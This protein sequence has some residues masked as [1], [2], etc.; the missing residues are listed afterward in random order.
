MFILMS[1]DLFIAKER[2]REALVKE[3]MQHIDWSDL[4]QYP[5]FETCD[6]SAARPEQKAC[7]ETTFARH[8]QATLQQ[9]QL[10]VQES[11]HDT[12]WI[13]LLIDNQGEIT[14]S[15]IE[16]QKETAAE[17]P[18]LDSILKRS[19]TAL[20]GIYP[21]LKRDIPVAAKFRVPVVLHVE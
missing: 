1:C 15:A 14:V 7:F 20:P 16:K 5:L 4:D 8:L 18:Q 17:L 3:E 2:T 21:P 10:I 12:V 11:I 6:E 13:Y 9:H 19:I